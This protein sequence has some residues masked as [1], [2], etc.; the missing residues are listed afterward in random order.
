M[1]YHFMPF[2]LQFDYAS[3]INKYV[4]LVPDME[5]WICIW[6]GDT[7]RT[8]PS[9]GEDIAEMIKAN[10]E[11][12]LLTT[13]STRTGVHQQRFGNRISPESNLIKLHNITESQHVRVQSYK[14][15]EI[16]HPV[17]GY[18]LIFRKKLAVEFPFQRSSTGILGV[19]GSWSK[20]LLEAGKKVGVCKRIV[21]IH[22]YR[23]NKN[24]KDTSHLRRQE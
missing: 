14:A 24:R 4:S 20:R 21:T 23:L 7:I 18:L 11:F 8:R 5:D 12:D 17:A 10:P 1:I 9:W 6:D 13:V 2:S 19:D 16:K 3:E 15:F 22:F